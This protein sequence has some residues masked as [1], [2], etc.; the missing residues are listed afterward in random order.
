MSQVFHR[1]TIGLS[2]VNN[3]VQKNLFALSKATAKIAGVFGVFGALFSIVMA[4]I[5]GPGSESPELKLMRTEFDKLSEKVDTIARSLKDTKKLITVEAQRAAYIRHE[6]K[7][8]QGYLALK[9][10]L[11]KID[12]VKCYDIKECKRNKTKVAEDYIAAMKVQ[13]N[14]EAILRGVTEEGAFGKPLLFL[15]KEQSECNVP[16]INLFVNKITA[17]ITKGMTVSMFYDLMTKTDYNVLD[18]TVRT[19]KML[20]ILN[21]RQ[22]DF[23]DECFD[24]FDYWMTLDVENSH[25]EF[26]ADIQD[27]NTKLLRTLRSKYPWIYWHVVTYKG[28]DEPET[29]PSNTPRRHLYSSS[30]THDVHSFVIPSNTAAVGNIQTI[31]KKWKKILTS[32]NSDPKT[33][34]QDLDYRLKKDFTLEKKIQ[35]F[36]ILPGKEWIL[37]HYKDR[38]EQQT[39]G[40]DDATSA[41]VFVSKSSQGFVVAVS[42]IQAEYPPKCTKTCSG[43]GDCYIYPYSMR[44]GCRCKLGYSGEKCNSSGTSLKLLSAV[45][46]ILETTMKLPSFASIQHTIEDTQLY[47]KTSIQNIQKSLTQLGQRIDEQFKSLGEFMSKKF[48]WFSILLKYKEAIEN[49]NYFHSISNEKISSFQQNITISTVTSNTEREIFAKA[50]DEEIA[51]FLLA[52]DGIRKWLYQIN[53][54]IVGRRDSQFNAHKPLLFVVMDKYKSRICLPDYKKEITRT[55]RQLMLLQLQGYML[56]SKAYS[57]VN[58]DSSAI[59]EKYTKILKSQQQYFRDTTCEVKIPHSKNFKDCTDGYYLHKSLRVEPS[60]SDGY[61]VQGTCVLM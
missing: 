56:W 34:V 5:P 46:S 1:G 21:S 3:V 40:V 19:D 10:C 28:T 7:I 13:G 26:T 47:L 6:N 20:R 14:V 54:L 44:T 12:N 60:C 58:R 25:E 41:N 9:T 33:A 30:E 39:L 29:G 35:S 15:I 45:N 32:I 38:I 24:N 8:H 55:Y 16:K 61:F 2:S 52:P 17:L 31:I 37:G 18:S 27:T 51:T 48:E 23:Q 11:K 42:F 49:L 59:S 50:E 53:F 22:Q 43:N 57:I 36:A 4:F